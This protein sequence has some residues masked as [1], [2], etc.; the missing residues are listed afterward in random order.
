MQIMEKVNTCSELLTQ[1]STALAKTVKGLAI[2]F[3]KGRLIIASIVFVIWH[4]HFNVNAQ[5]RL[6]TLTNSKTLVKYNAAYTLKDE[7]FSLSRLGVDWSGKLHFS[8]N[9]IA[10]IELSAAFADDDVGLGTT[11]NFA[12]FNQTIVTQ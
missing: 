11:N 6:P 12:R 2:Y 10:Q 8:S 5:T 4:L 9:W 1:V 7:R 3:L